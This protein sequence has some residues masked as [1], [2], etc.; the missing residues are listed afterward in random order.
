MSC[1][2]NLP[3]IYQNN[4]KKLTALTTIPI[5]FQ[6]IYQL[7]V[8][9]IK[10]GLDSSLKAHHRRRT[11][12][13]VGSEQQYIVQVVTGTHTSIRLIKEAIRKCYHESHSKRLTKRIITYL[14]WLSSA[15]Y[16]PRDKNQL[17]CLTKS[18]REREVPFTPHIIRIVLAAAQGY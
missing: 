8:Y 12:P 13:R 11:V 5:C 17:N 16:C 6:N 2:Q 10:G 14:T 18:Q 4:F 15:S 9:I 7:F 1:Q 3:T